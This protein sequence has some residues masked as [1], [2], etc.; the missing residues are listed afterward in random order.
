[1]TKTVREFYRQ[2]NND[3]TIPTIEGQGNFT[4]DEMIWFAEQAVKLFAIPDVSNQRELLIAFLKK[5]KK[6]DKLTPFQKGF[7]NVFIKRNL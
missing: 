1:M 3:N 6:V 4:A 2:L 7:I 5:Y